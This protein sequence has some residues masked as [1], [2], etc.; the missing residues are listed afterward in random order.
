[1]TKTKPSIVVQQS[2][3][4]GSGIFST[5]QFPKGQKLFT[6]DGPIIAFTKLHHWRLG[7]HWLN[8]GKDRWMVPYANNVWRFVNHSCDPNAIVT[9]GR[10][11]IALRPI[12]TGEEITID[13]SCTE[14]QRA[15]HMSCRCGAT[16]CRKIIKSI[17]FLPEPLFQ[18]YRQYIPTF[19]RKEYAKNKV[20]IVKRGSIQTVLAKR[21]V[22]KSESIFRVEGPTILYKK[23]PSYR[24]GYRWLG[25]GLNSWIIPEEDNPWSFLNHSCNPNV[26]LNNTHE[27]VALRTIQHGEE[28]T[29]DDSITEGDPRWRKKCSCGA[30]NCRGIVRSIRFLPQETYNKYL[31]FVPSFL[32]K[33][34]MEHSQ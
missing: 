8:V 4:H 3:I 5:R 32:Q 30:K 12:R 34:Y 18:K 23:P 2:R 31:P 7:P 28:L 14:S 9:T 33:I 22:H 10:K 1:M 25:V 26:G 11:V 19:L 20:V 27:V 29:I 13:Y 24:L 17:H 15:W 16:N 21:K 6:A